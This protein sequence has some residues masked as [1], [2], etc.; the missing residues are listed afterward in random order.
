MKK[1]P[2]GLHAVAYSQ[3]CAVARLQIA[4][5]SATISF[6]ILS[7]LEIATDKPGRDLI[8]ANKLWRN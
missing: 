1:N 2:T 3:N 6:G 5:I 7:T 4:I 8:V